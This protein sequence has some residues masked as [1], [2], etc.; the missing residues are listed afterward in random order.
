MLVLSRKLGE[1]I[2]LDVPDQ[3]PIVVTVV[4]IDRGK[5]KIGFDADRTVIISREELLP[6]RP[7]EKE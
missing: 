1:R 7:K 3:K 5:I 2:I 6:R 4:E